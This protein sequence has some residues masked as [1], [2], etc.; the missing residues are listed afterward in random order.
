MG[1]EKKRNP[2]QEEIM[3]DIIEKLKDY[4]SASKEKTGEDLVTLRIQELVYNKLLVMS[5]AS[6]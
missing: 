3:A 5:Y 2:F 4:E 6:S 1:R